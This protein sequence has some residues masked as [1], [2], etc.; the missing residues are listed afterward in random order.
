MRYTQ[1]SQLNNSR[2]QAKDPVRF[3]LIVGIVGAILLGAGYMATNSVANAVIPK[4][5]TSLPSA[6]KTKVLNVRRAPTTL[7]TVTRT[8]QLS[9]ALQSFQ[10][11]IPSGSCASVQWLHGE[12]LG[13]ETQQQLTPASTQKIVT[14]I[15]A[16]EVL[17]PTFTFETTVFA[18]GDA[19]TGV[20]QD[21]Y[22]VGGGD[23]VLV[24]KEYGPTEKYP[25]I[26]GTSL[27]GLADSIVA[28]GV[29]S[30]T[31][32]I[33][34]IDARYDAIRF[35]DVWPKEF[36]VVE[37][38]P[39]G[40]LMVNDGAVI[41][42][43][44]KPDNPA[45]AASAELRSLL[46]ARGVLVAQDSRYELSVP[47]NATKVA[48]ITSA[49]LTQIVQEMLVNSDNNTAE[50]LVKEI[51][52][53]K[54]K[55]GTTAAGIQVIQELM[56]TWKL[57]TQAVVVDGSGLSSMNKMS[58]ANFLAL[59]TKAESTLPGLLPI[60]GQTGTLRSVFTDS[61]MEGRLVGKT[62]TLT[63]VKALAGYLPLEGNSPVRFALIMN[64]S[65][66]DNQGSYRPIWL[67]FGSAL[68]KARA[69]PTPQ[70]LMP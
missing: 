17:S 14:A 18:T 64:T 48:S 44:I 29:R 62:G 2:R 40:A 55:L 7:S 24:R 5:N 53:A 27:E 45:I 68:N 6:A 47:S 37:A 1:V 38:G 46:G 13:V 19:S 33:V 25:T 57:P 12:Q 43:P 22:F 28:A 21:L 65:G 58:C 39:L 23:P 42:A 10:A 32:S 16:L 63:G 8:N 41:G 36:N 50:L 70:Q 51:G 49:P 60:A 69:V 26:N 31:G 66:I 61:S 30:V 52:F 3:L 56:T 59:L 9:R 11:Q 15:A 67:S 34:G 35:L 20:V 54:K 4:S